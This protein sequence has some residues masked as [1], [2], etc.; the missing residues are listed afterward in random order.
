MSELVWG[1]PEGQVFESGVDRGVFFPRGADG[2]AWNGL[3]SVQD[4]PTGGELQERFMD[5]RKY[6]VQK[7]RESFAATITAFMYPFAA[8]TALGRVAWSSRSPGLYAAQQT[9][10][11]FDFSY[12]TLIGTGADQDAGYKIHLVY[13]ALASP[14]EVA[15]STVGD[16]IDLVDF[17]WQLTTRPE[18]MEDNFGNE[19]YSAHLVIDTRYTYAWA[20]EALEAILYGSASTTARMP[21]ATEVFKLYEDASILRIT[22]HGDGSWTADGPD[23]I[24]KMLDAT[25][26]EITWPSAVYIDS[27]S[28]QISSL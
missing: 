21:T 26:F 28:Y 7:N 15:Y 20:I 17:G 6:T 4:N 3:V 1:L 10:R 14:S 16:A 12:R 2:V 22:D 25:S 27:E 8:E 24:I 5:G 11:E 19:V 18:V 13:N 9:M 23:D